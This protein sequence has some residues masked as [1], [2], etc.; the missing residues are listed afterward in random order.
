MGT[1]RFLEF[2]EDARYPQW[3]LWMKVGYALVLHH[4]GVVY[5]ADFRRCGR[6]NLCNNSVLHVTNAEGQSINRGEVVNQV[7]R[8]DD[9]PPTWC[10][11]K[12]SYLR[13]EDWGRKVYSV[14]NNPVLKV[15]YGNE[16]IH[17]DSE[18][19]QFNIR[20]VSPNRHP[21]ERGSRSEYEARDSH[22]DE[23]RNTYENRKFTQIRDTC[24]WR[25]SH[26]LS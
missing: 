16:F 3:L 9:Y 7:C 11:C 13:G 21:W 5:I 6:L 19:E 26:A 15:N 8:P 10:V 14:R 24:M 1:S 12:T 17:W 2:C 18:Q 23:A 4:S 20:P 25:V 22:S